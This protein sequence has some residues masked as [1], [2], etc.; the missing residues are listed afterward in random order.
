MQIHLCQESYI[1]YTARLMITLQSKQTEEYL[2]FL[3]V[4]NKNVVGRIGNAT[5]CVVIR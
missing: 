5:L 2:Y 1:K 3:H 4:G